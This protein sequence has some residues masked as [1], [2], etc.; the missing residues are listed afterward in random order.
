MITLLE[1]GNLSVYGFWLKWLR[2][3]LPFEKCY[4]ELWLLGVGVSI[5]FKPNK[6]R[7]IY[8]DQKIFCLTKKIQKNMYS[9]SLNNKNLRNRFNNST[10]KNIF[11][12]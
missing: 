7:N 3:I 4:Y 6:K 12:F 2:V 11:S 5:S 1:D 10:C 9:D 8:K